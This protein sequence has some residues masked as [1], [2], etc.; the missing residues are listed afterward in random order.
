[1][2]IEPGGREP[3]HLR[4]RYGRSTSCS[5]SVG[6]VI[7]GSSPGMPVAAD[8]V[9]ITGCLVAWRE[10]PSP[11]KNEFVEIFQRF[12]GGHVVRLGAANVAQV[13]KACVNHSESKAW[14]H[15]VRLLFATAHLLAGSILLVLH[16]A[17]CVIERED[18]RGVSP[19]S[20]SFRENACRNACVSSFV[21]SCGT[22]DM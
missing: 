17:L 16:I 10:D 7:D 6:L 12:D 9:I 11:T 22:V 8:F 19:P 18:D 1:M 14:P 15:R 20:G 3:V 2:R 21:Y 13:Y 4:R 5:S